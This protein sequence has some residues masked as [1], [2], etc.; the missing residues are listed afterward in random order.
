MRRRY[1]D[2]TQRKAVPLRPLPDCHRTPE[3]N[4][5]TSCQFT[6]N[7]PSTPPSVWSPVRRLPDGSEVTRALK[8]R[9]K[10]VLR[11]ISLLQAKQGGADIPVCGVARKQRQATLVAG[12]MMKHFVNPAPSRIWA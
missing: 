1:C 4:A 12:C 10:A 7:P 8:F 11:A 2:A 9:L 3:I 6:L 5:R